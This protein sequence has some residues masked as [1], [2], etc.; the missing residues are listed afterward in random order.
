[1]PLIQIA[2]GKSSVGECDLPLHYS[3]RPCFGISLI[4]SPNTLFGKGDCRCSERVVAV[5]R[6][7]WLSLFGAGG[8]QMPFANIADGICDHCRWHLRPSQM[9]FA[10]HLFRT[11]FTTISEH[12]PPGFPNIGNHPFRR[13]K[14]GDRK[15]D[16]GLAEPR[17]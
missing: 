3:N 17:R 11:S 1:M 13:R 16:D 8:R 6:K 4:P 14:V 12:R 9:A 2:L 5:V 10:H 7:R 15:M